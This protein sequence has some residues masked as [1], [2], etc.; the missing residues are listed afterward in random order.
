MDSRVC[1]WLR[2]VTLVSLAS[3]GNAGDHPA[4]TAQV[5][6]GGLPSSANCST[7]APS[8]SA[9]IA[10]IVSERCLTCHFAGNTI[11][12]TAL[13]DQAS[14]YNYRSIVLTQVYQCRMPPTGVDNLTTPERALLLQ[15]LVCNAPDN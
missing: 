6:P 13:A 5:C 2:T 14:L 10:P 11:S 1:R 7:E 4:D 12:G 15:Y 9:K 3:C 8:Y